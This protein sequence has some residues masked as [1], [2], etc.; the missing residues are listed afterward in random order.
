[1]AHI[2]HEINNILTIILANTEMPQLKLDADSS[3]RKNLQKAEQAVGSSRKLLQLL[4]SYAS[5]K[6]ED[7]HSFDLTH[8]ATKPLELMGKLLPRSISLVTNLPDKPILVLGREI[9]IQQVMLSLFANSISAIGSGSGEISM[10]LERVKVSKGQGTED[11]KCKMTF[12][13][14]GSGI[15]EAHMKRIFEPYFT[16]GKLEHSSGMGLTVTKAIVEDMQGE[17]SLCSDPQQPA[18]F[19]VILPIVLP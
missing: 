15:E 1:M 4:S 5:G 14:S 11:A 13:D 19:S 3:A 9:E 17:I 16:T 18:I 6:Q 8:I 10:T 12:S 7:V 2:I